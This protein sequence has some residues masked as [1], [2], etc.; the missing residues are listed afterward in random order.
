MITDYHLDVIDISAEFLEE[1]E[2]DILESRKLNQEEFY[3][4]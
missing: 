2:S 4:N 1:F 3:P